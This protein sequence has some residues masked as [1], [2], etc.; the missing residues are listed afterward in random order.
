MLHF[1]DTIPRQT[2]P[3]W[4]KHT[5]TYVC[6]S[7]QLSAVYSL[8]GST[9]WT[10][11][12]VQL[13][14]QSQVRD[15]NPPSSATTTDPHRRVEGTKTTSNTKLQGK[16]TQWHR[17]L[18]RDRHVDMWLLPI[19]V[20]LLECQRADYLT[21]KIRLVPVNVLIAATVWLRWYCA[22]YYYGFLFPGT[23]H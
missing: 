20:S 9:E 6:A 17:N 15:L 5:G 11:A 3:V 14:F 23:E 16:E 12:D 10:H 18:Q 22:G 13:W 2:F 8:Y 1:D 21:A 7:R 19:F 4:V